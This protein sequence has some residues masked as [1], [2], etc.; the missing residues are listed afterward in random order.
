VAF[1]LDEGSQLEPMAF[2]RDFSGGSQ[3]E[4]LPR[5]LPA[6]TRAYFS[7]LV[8]PGRSNFAITPQIRVSVMSVYPSHRLSDLCVAAN[9]ALELVTLN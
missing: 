3:P 7:H 6:I 4:P 1:D 9:S 2:E 5:V 8:F